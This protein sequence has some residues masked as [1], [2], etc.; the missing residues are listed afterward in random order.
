M[1][2]SLSDKLENVFRRIRGTG[3]LTEANIEEAMRDVR[4]ALLEADVHFQVTKSFVERVR[5]RALGQDVLRS[6]TP[7]QHLIKIVHEELVG[8]MGGAAGKLDLSGDVPAILMLVGL[9]GS[10][11]TTTAAKLARST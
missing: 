8:V 11:K 5:E 6:L 1:F 3:K 2:D 9:Q 7:E 4:M 10:G